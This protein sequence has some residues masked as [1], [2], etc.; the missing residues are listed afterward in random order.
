MPIL[1]TATIEDPS[2][3]AVASGF[4]IS[5]ASPAP[6]GNSDKTHDAFVRAYKKKYQADPGVLSDT[7]YDCAKILINAWRHSPDPQGVMAYI[8]GLK[9]WSGAS[10]TLTFDRNGD[11]RKHYALKT[12]RDGKFAWK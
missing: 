11:V 10:G 1:A 9:D 2:V 8:H 12:V 7:G 3:A 4:D 5:F 6:T